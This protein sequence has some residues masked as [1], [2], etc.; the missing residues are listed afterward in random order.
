MD[1]F[2]TGAT[3]YIGGAVADALLR[4]GHN[5]TGLA[6][7]VRN[8]RDL[9]RRGMRVRPG[10]LLKPRTVAEGARSAQGTI[11]TANTNDAEAA[12]AERAAVLEILESLAG[13]G[14]PFIYTSGIWVLG[15]TGNVP[16]DENA[17]VH[18]V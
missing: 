16:A 5:V 15:S 12:A 3:G 14:K 17:P 1:V 8:A 2:V 9:E 13:S 7:S 11:H 10:D 6:R 18:P 4:A